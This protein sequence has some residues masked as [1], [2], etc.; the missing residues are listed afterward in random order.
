MLEMPQWTHNANCWR[1]HICYTLGM[2]ATSPTR[3]C[4]CSLFQVDNVH[5]AIWVNGEIVHGNHDRKPGWLWL[6]K[7]VETPYRHTRTLP[8]FF[9]PGGFWLSTVPSS[10]WFSRSPPSS[11]K[12]KQKQTAYNHMLQHC[13]PLAYQRRHCSKF[14]SDD[15]WSTGWEGGEHTLRLSLASR[16]LVRSP[17]PKVQP[18]MVTYARASQSGWTRADL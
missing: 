4:G 13:V 10:G 9:P 1:T 15:K 7:D 17:L 2:R 14:S 8:P 3:L 12:I 16:G 6:L 11:S 5:I 18:T